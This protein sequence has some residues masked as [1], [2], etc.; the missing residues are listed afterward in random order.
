MDEEKDIGQEETK[1][2]AN[3]RTES[4]K[5]KEEVTFENPELLRRGFG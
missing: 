4:E 1:Q 2:K 5:V 3:K